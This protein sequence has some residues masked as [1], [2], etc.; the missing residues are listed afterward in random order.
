MAYC[1]KHSCNNCIECAI[2]NQTKEIQAT[3]RELREP[4]KDYPVREAPRLPWYKRIW[5]FLNSTPDFD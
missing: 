3:I 2:E 1:Q 5:I 4:P